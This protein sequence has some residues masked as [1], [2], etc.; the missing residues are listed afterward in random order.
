MTY[1]RRYRYPWFD[2]RVLLVQMRKTNNNFVKIVRI[3][4]T[5]D[6][7]KHYPQNYYGYIRRSGNEKKLTTH[8]W[9]ITIT[10][11]VHCSKQWFEIKKN[12]DIIM[13]ILYLLLYSLGLAHST[14]VKSV[15]AIFRVYCSVPTWCKVCLC[16]HCLL[17]N[18]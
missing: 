18:S 17:F 10:M 16:N 4:K 2:I 5:I 9:S 1:L 6:S 14:G 15:Q 12:P 8:F 3:L 11:H 7:L 13:H